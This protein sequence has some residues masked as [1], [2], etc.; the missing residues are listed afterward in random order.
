MEDAPNSAA[1][2]A[3]RSG[4]LQHVIPTA[5]PVPNESRVVREGPLR[6]TLSALAQAYREAN[7]R[8]GGNWR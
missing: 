1:E 5:E 3:T 6:S 8:T 4:S 7:Q 2:D